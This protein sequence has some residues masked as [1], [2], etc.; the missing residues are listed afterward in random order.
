MRTVTLRIDACL[1]GN[2]ALPL[3]GLPC[4]FADTSDDYYTCAHP[5]MT[6][7][8]ELPDKGVHKNCPLR[9]KK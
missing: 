2:T 7:T 5:R 4:P 6:D 3:A 8:T 1:D 9:T